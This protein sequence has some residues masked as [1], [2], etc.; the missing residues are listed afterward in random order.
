MKRI[1]HSKIKYFMT[2][3]NTPKK[4]EPNVIDMNA[5]PDVRKHNQILQKKSL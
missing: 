1:T 4:N 5:T 3:V 2:N